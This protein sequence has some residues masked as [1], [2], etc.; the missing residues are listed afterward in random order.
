MRGYDVA[1]NE[2]F[3]RLTNN[4]QVQGSLEQLI[5]NSLANS[6]VPCKESVSLDLNPKTS[7]MNPPTAA[8]LGQR[9]KKEGSGLSTLKSDE[10]ES[11][12]SLKTMT[13]K[14]LGKLFLMLVKDLLLPSSFS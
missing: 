9:N 11:A 14:Q 4:M 6:S 1:H 12:E 10:I 7:D 2:C 13:L 8:S 5:R 3:S